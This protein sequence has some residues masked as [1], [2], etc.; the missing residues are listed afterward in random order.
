M[1][2]QIISE[3]ARICIQL[4]IDHAV[5]S[6]GSRNAPLIIAFAKNPAFHCFSI[7]DERSAG[8]FALGMA[9]Q[10]Q[11]PVVLICTSGTAALNYAPALAEA[12]YQ[13]V[14]LLALTADRPSEWI[15]QNDGQS[16]RQQNIYSS[17]VKKSFTLPIDTFNPED[18][19]HARR[20]MSGAVNFALSGGHG[21]VHVNVPLREP[22]YAEQTV[23][24]NDVPVIRITQSTPAPGE[25]RWQ[26]I[27]E[28][29]SSFNKKLIVCGFMNSNHEL[30]RLLD[31]MSRNDE[32]VVIAENLSNL[33]SREF[34]DTPEPFLARLSGSDREDFTPELLV[35]IGG[36]VVSKNLKNYLRKYRPAEH[37]HIDPDDLFIDTYRVLTQSV[38]AVPLEFFTR[39][40]GTGK[41]DLLYMQLARERHT[42]CGQ[43]HNEFIRSAVFSDLSSARLQPAPCEQH[44]RPLCP[45]LQQ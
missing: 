20:I 3:L 8:Y 18:L 21:P 44:P 22:L 17:F 11:K 32:A 26:S 39:V 33:F 23:V 28:K 34:V 40:A 45:A 15:D 4:G 29:W 10:L 2:H 14:P 1:A 9:R 27:R 6:P 31:Q 30:S 38:P 7:S 41:N 42:S 5:I 37:W 24:Q 36:S 43:L 16:I 12:F 13:K 35:T 19:W 25:S